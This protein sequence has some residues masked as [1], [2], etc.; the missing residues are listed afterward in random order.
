MM[1]VSNQHKWLRTKRIATFI[2]FIGA[3]TAAGGLEG[4][5]EIPNLPLALVLIVASL[6]GVL[7]ITK[8]Y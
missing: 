8:H 3:I 1:R 5:K 7:N 4:D 6:Y 2:C